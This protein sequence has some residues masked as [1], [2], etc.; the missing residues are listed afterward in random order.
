M[1]RPF[2]SALLCLSCACQS[3]DL[4]PKPPSEAEYDRG[5]VVIYP[6][7]SSTRD[8]MIGIYVGLKD[9]GIDQAIELRPWGINAQHWLNITGDTRNR[10]WA[11]DEAARIAQYQDAHPNCPVTLIGFSAGSGIACWVA[12]FMPSGHMVDK[13]ITLVPGLSKDFDLT[14]V[15]ARSR[16]GVVNYYSPIDFSSVLLTASWGSIDRDFGV[17]AAQAGFT[18]QDEKLVQFSWEPRM[19]LY[20]NFGNHADILPNSL[21]FRDFVAPWVAG[22]DPA[23]RGARH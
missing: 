12:E 2:L 19:M 21:W 14:G 16:G 6:G 1:R 18:H 3:I 11:A 23:A 4:S 17:P 10:V 13:V 15:L 8:E 22:Y 7:S 5:L 20:F 9:A